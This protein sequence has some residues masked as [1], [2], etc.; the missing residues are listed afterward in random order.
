MVAAILGGH[1]R[2]LGA[3]CSFGGDVYGVILLMFDDGDDG[4]NDDHYLYCR[5]T[6][7]AILLVE[8]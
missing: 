3:G 7:S 8:N 1:C 2:G 6:T 5:S 4:D